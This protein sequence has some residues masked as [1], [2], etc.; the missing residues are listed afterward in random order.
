MNDMGLVYDVNKTF[1]VPKAKE[2]LKPLNLE[3]DIPMDCD[4]NPKTS[5]KKHVAEEIEKDAKTPRVKKFRLPNN[6]VQ[7]LTYLMDKYG[8]D[9]KVTAKTSTFSLV[10]NKLG[11]HFRRGWGQNYRGLM[12]YFQPLKKIIGLLSK[13]GNPTMFT[14]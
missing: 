5:I 14:N 13:R 7:W 3:E 12:S 9:F 10:K 2:S 11:C 1:R 4:V 8:E 6:Q